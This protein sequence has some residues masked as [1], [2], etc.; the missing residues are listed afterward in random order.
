M[1]LD[2]FLDP[3]M[4]A[5]SPEVAQRL[6]NLR[7]SS[8]VQ[9]RAATLAEKANLG[10]LSAEEEAEYKGFVDAVDIIAIMQS[11]ARKVLSQKKS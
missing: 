4:D 6:V 10:T 5:I 3:L 1:Y 9:A 7:A 11:K 8:D 2:R